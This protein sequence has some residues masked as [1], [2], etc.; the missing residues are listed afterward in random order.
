MGHGGRCTGSMCGLHACGE[1]PPQWTRGGVH[2]SRSNG[3]PT[4]SPCECGWG[5]CCCCLST[6]AKLECAVEGGSIS[7]SLVS[8]N[9]VSTWDS[10]KFQP[11][12]DRHVAKLKGNTIIFC[13]NREPSTVY[14]IGTRENL[15]VWREYCNDLHDEGREGKETPDDIIRCVCAMPWCSIFIML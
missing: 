13:R 7:P 10:S 15:P 9:L 8:S 14:T 3:C 1:K 5:F 4:K 2:L 12:W 11:V 6:Q